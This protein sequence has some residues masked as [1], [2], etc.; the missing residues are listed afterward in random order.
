MMLVRVLSYPMG[1]D[2]I[3]ARLFIILKVI[4]L[5]DFLKKA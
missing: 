5:K 1:Q 2:L 3:I 4:L